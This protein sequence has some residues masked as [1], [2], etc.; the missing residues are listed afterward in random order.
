MD[1]ILLQDILHNIPGCVPESDGTAQPVQ[2]Q[3]TEH[4]A[5]PMH[6]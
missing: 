3:G 4:H 5:P 1:K 6:E 2:P